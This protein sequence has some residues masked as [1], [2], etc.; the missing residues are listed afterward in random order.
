[1]K[2]ILNRDSDGKAQFE[3]TNIK[4]PKTIS[5][6]SIIGTNTIYDGDDFQENGYVYNN[7]QKRKWFRSCSRFGIKKLW[8]GRDNNLKYWHDLFYKLNTKIKTIRDEQ[9]NL[10]KPYE[11]KSEFKLYAKPTHKFDSNGKDYWVYDFRKDENGK[12]SYGFNWI[13]KPKKING[14]RF[15]EL[16][17]RADYYGKYRFAAENYFIDCVKSKLQKPTDIS[18]VEVNIGKF[19]LIFKSKTANY[20][21]FW[22]EF[23]SFGKIERLDFTEK[24]LY[25]N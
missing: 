17:L 21:Y 5:A 16:G 8:V 1:M 14:Q 15:Y 10:L 6:L 9:R 25:N 7:G 23:E 2:N 20:Q 24:Y 11:N 3:G 22:W 12:F 13:T 4:V 19:N 18:F